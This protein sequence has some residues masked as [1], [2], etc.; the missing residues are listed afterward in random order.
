M[1]F[2]N[3]SNFLGKNKQTLS[4]AMLSKRSNA[5]HPSHLAEY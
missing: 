1:S 3:A 4:L 5:L 2:A